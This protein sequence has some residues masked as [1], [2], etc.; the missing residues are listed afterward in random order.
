MIDLEFIVGHDPAVDRDGVGDYSE[1]VAEALSG[2]MR[3]DSSFVFRHLR[4]KPRG[5]SEW[6]RIF[7]F[8]KP[9]KIIHIQYPVEGWGRS[10][11]PGLLPAIARVLCP[12]TR[13]VVTLHE[14][15][16]MHFLR[17]MSITFVALLADA[18]VF[19]SAR[20]REAFSCSKVAAFARRGQLREF[21]PIAVNVD[22]PVVQADDIV[23]ARKEVLR[24]ELSSTVKGNDGGRPDEILLGYFGFIYEWKQPEKMLTVLSELTRAGYD[25]RLLMCGDFPA[26]HVIARNQFVQKISSMGLSDR[27]EL[28]GYID[29]TDS[30]ALNLLACDFVIQLFSDGLSA[31]RGSFWYALELG[32]SIVS[33]FPNDVSEFSELG[34]SFNPL[35]DKNIILVRADE[36]PEAIARELIGR[37]RPWNPQARR[38]VAPKW[39]DIASAHLACYTKLAP[40]FEGDHEGKIVGSN[41]SVSSSRKYNTADE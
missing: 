28:Y 5:L 30:L 27:V 7:G 19:A 21:I 35:T 11:M 18:L 32:A 17:R 20:E 22:I 13:L 6:L 25:A 3:M 37:W 12:S 15:R 4:F 8:F 39:S 1:K 31:R 14:W 9:G 40:T 10:I 33:T 26:D 24:R 41:V 2:K 29:D 23:A 36:S 16:S 34:I 38:N